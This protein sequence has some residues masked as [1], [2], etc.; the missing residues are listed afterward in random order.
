MSTHVTK[1]LP[2]HQHRVKCGHS[3]VEPTACDSIYMLVTAADDQ[4]AP[5]TTLGGGSIGITS[6]GEQ[7]GTTEG[8]LNVVV[9]S[10]MEN[11]GTSSDRGQRVVHHNVQ[12]RNSELAALLS[13]A[14]T[15]MVAKVIHLDCN[16]C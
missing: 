11:V 16:G 9:T 15:V 3:V 12:R 1:T 4:L 13:P 7:Q 10:D 6:D 8:G 14:R 5:V 2:S